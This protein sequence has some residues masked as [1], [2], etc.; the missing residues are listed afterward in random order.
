MS[1]KA[2]QKIPKFQL[3][4]LNEVELIFQ[5]VLD[6][7]TPYFRSVVGRA[8]G[9]NSEQELNW[10]PIVSL[11]SLRAEVGG[12]FDILKNRWIQAGFPLRAHRGDAGENF[13]MSEEGW[14]ELCSWLASRGYQAKPGGSDSRTLFQIKKID[15]SR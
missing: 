1:K 13:S 2:E 14:I 5:E 3:D 8:R 9:S 15:H 10:V 7:L 11:S 6:E 12:R 4:V